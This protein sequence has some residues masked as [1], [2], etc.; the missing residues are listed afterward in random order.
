MKSDP[1]L[2]DLKMQG[3]VLRADIDGTMSFV[4]WSQ[5]GFKKN[6]GGVRRPRTQSREVDWGLEPRK[7]R[8]PQERMESLM[9]R[10]GPDLRVY[11]KTDVGEEA[12]ELAQD[13]ITQVDKENEAAEAKKV[14]RTAPS[15]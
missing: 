15:E 1:E 13:T 6:G 5:S 7:R 2:A 9:G 11:L 12:R 8:T 4:H 3:Y 14:V 10:V